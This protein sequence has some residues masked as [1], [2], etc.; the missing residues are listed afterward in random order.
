IIRKEGAPSNGTKNQATKQESGSSPGVLVVQDRHRP[1]RGVRSLRFGAR[2]PAR[3]GHP[4]LHPGVP[5]APR[6][7]D[8]H[9]QEGKLTW[10]GQ[11][12]SPT[13]RR[14]SW[15]LKNSNTAATGRWS[16]ARAGT[17]SSSTKTQ[18]T[19]RTGSPLW[20]SLT[21]TSLSTREPTAGST[22]S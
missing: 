17:T 14:T 20:R 13:N 1:H 3:C 7:R 15:S 11:E 18:S 10:A 4:S 8:R 12:H 19:N 16:H 21:P 9:Q 6:D 5:R 2:L 22:S